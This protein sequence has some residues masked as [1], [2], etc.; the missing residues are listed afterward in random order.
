MSQQLQRTM[1]RIPRDVKQRHGYDA[2]MRERPAGEPRHRWA[3]VWL[4]KHRFL[5]DV[6]SRKVGEVQHPRLVK[7]KGRDAN[8]TEFLATYEW[9]A[10]RM[11]VLKRYG[12]RCQCCGATPAD[13]VRMHVDHIKPRRDFPELA[14]EESNLQ[15][16]C[17]VCN[18]GKGNWDRTDWRPAETDEG[19]DA[20]VMPIWYRQEIKH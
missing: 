15:V 2:H 16:L 18:H 5:T 12:T 14:L 8:G 1:K 17:E 7:A 4:V 9:R 3:R 20:A 6:E 19:R 11:K 13:G 10:L